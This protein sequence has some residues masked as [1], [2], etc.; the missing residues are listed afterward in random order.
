MN[1]KIQRPGVCNAAETLLVH[2][3]VG[4]AFVPRIVRGALHAAGVVVC[5]EERALALAQGAGG[6]TLQ[7]TASSPAPLV[8]PAGERVGSEYLALTLA[9]AVV[10]S[11]EEAI[12]AHGQRLRQRALR[13]DRDE[14]HGRPRARSS[15]GVDAACVYVNASTRFTDGGE[16]GDGGG[17]RQLDAEAARARADRI[18]RA[19]HVQV[20]GGG[21]R[22]RPLQWSVRWGAGRDASLAGHPRRHVQPAAPRPPGDRAQGALA[23]SSRCSGCALDSRAHP[24]TQAGRGRTRGCEHRLAMCRRL[25]DSADGS[26]HEFVVD[27]LE[28]ERD[29]P[30]YTVDTLKSHT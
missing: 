30:S 8:E 7:H 27:A 21:R 26:V 23:G 13:G 14:R 25:L 18:A 6:S 2:S 5:G 3:E 16:F 20:P 19:V 17:D 28:L 12:E 22:T 9:V 10:N 11:V 4:A 24:A 29:G 1:A 15:W